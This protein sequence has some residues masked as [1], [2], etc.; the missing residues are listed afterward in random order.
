MFITNVGNIIYI[1]KWW[2]GTIKHW[3]VNDGIWKNK[4]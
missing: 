3:T 1:E 2:D 4:R